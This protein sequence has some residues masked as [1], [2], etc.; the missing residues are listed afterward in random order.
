M[1]FKWLKNRAEKRRHAENIYNKAAT[2]ARHPYFYQALQVSDSITGRYELLCVHIY[3]VLERLR[4]EEGQSEL[5]QQITEILVKELERAYRDNGFRDL[6]IPKN[7]KKLI[8]G[9]YQRA[10]A[11]KAGIAQSSTQRLADAINTYIYANNSAVEERANKFA[12]YMLAAN[13]H[14][15]SISIKEIKN[16]DFAFISPNMESA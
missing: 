14:L 10:E 15:Q 16:A 9:F 12:V 7:I 6:S 8:A 2:H 3:L 11:Y 1:L 4:R 13:A 5:S